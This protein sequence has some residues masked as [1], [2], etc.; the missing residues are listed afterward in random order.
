MDLTKRK[1]DKIDESLML[2]DSNILK[3]FSPFKQAIDTVSGAADAELS[4]S[5]YFGVPDQVKNIELKKNS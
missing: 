2:D 5:Q 4:I 3:D 1:K